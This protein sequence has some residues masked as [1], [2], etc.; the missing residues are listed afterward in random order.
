MKQDEFKLWVGGAAGDG[1]ASVGNTFFQICARLGLHGFAYNSY[2]SVIRGG[3]VL[4]QAHFAPRKVYTQTDQCDILIA[5]NQDTIEREA[6]TAVKGVLFNSDRLRLD[7]AKLPAGS[8]SLGLPVSKMA[9]KPLLQ[10]TVAL[11]AAAEIVGMEFRIVGDLL[12]DRFQKKGK[13][14]VNENVEAAR[15]GYDYARKNFPSFGIQLPTL[16]EP[17]MVM[18]GN[19]AIALGLLAAGCKFY[20]AYPMTPASSIM[21]WLSPRAAR[22]GVVFKQAEDEIA[23][24]NMALGAAFAGIRAMTATSGGGFALMTEAIGLAGMAEIPVVIGL[25]QRGGPSTGLPTKT[26]Q[27]DLFQ[28][29]G[30]SQGDFPKIILA[31]TTIPEAFEATVEAFNLA[32]KYQCPVILMSDLLLSEHA[33]TVE[34]GRLNLDVAIERGVWARP[35]ADGDF[36][37]YVDTDTGVSPRAI[38]GQEGLIHTGISDEH[39]E[40]GHLISD[41]A[42][43]PAMRIRM[44]N[45][46]M[47]KMEFA[48]RDLKAPGIE[49]PPEAQLTLVGWGSTC[50]MMAHLMRDL[51]ANGD[52]R[53]NI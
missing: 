16:K 20:S 21:H 36:R 50:N 49:G 42:T 15:A 10:N 6:K 13:E 32:E 3:H 46:R 7:P 25:V 18:T 43:D 37:R 30:A 48:A 53:V 28:A 12:R 19:E 45:K 47:R 24:V 44:M 40:K 1:I 23:A 8:R 39:D 35:G 41:V 2:Q 17:K 51:N 52:N 29:L 14:I 27:A 9:S 38:P 26:E 22:Y 4:W 31:P 34:A 11:G 5:L 33:E